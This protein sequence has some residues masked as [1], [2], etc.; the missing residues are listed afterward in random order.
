MDTLYV[1]SAIIAMS[2]ITFALR[3]IPF[4]MPKH[5]FEAPFIRNLARLMPFLI[6]AILVLNAF[7]DAELGW[8]GSAIPLLMG[9]GVVA[10]LQIGLR[11]PLISIIGGVGAHILALMLLQ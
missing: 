10:L 5:V 7:K 8:T 6:M 2:I 11:F 1:I 3:A 9:V 4:I